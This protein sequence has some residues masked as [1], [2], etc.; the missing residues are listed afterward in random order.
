MRFSLCWMVSR[1]AAGV[2]AVFLTGV[3][4]ASETSTPLYVA[5]GLILGL[6]IGDII[7]DRTSRHLSRFTEQLHA[8]TDVIIFG[9]APAFLTFTLIQHL[10]PADTGWDRVGRALCVLYVLGFIVT[11]ARFRTTADRR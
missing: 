2:I 6:L 3:S 1:G 11:A 8:L 7:T 4:L 5:F 9:I 10:A